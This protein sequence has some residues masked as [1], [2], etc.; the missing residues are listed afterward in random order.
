MKKLSIFTVV[1]V[2][3][4][5]TTVSSA[6]YRSY[7]DM[8]SNWNIVQK[9]SFATRMIAVYERSNDRFLNLI[10]R[11][12]RFSHYSWY[13]NLV[14]RYEWQLTEIARYQEV[15]NDSQA[16]LVVDTIV[17][18]VPGKVVQRRT[19]IEVTRDTKIVE[20]IFAGMVREY[21][22]TTVVLHTPVRTINYVNRKTTK[23]YSDGTR[24]TDSDVTVTSV[25]DTVDVETKV[26]REFLR[27][28]PVVVADRDNA[29][30]VPRME[31]L[32]EAEYLAL[33]DVNYYQSEVYYTAVKNMN[34][35]I[36]D[37]YTNEVLGKWFGNNLDT[38]GAPA[39]WSR[40][41]TGAGSKIAI[42]DT[43]IDLDHPEF[44]G[45]IAAAEC[46]S[47]ACE[48]GNE[49]IDDQNRYSHGT[50]VAGI[51]A[52]AFDGTG[53]TGVAPEAELLI[54]KLAHDW[55]FFDFSRL[56]DGIQWAVNQGADVMNVSANTNPDLI[57]RRSLI[58]L[59]DGTFY[60]ND[61][62]HGGLY[63][64]DGYNATYRSNTY[65]Q[66]FVEAMKGHEAILVMS[67]GN[68][69][70]PISGVPT[71]IALDDEV[72]DR[73]LVVGNYDMRTRDLYRGSNAAGTLCLQPT[74]DNQC[75]QQGRISDRYLMAPGLYIASTDR[76]GSYRT[77]SGTS[78]AAPHVAGAVAIVRQ[79]WPH[80]T[81]ANLSKLLLDTANTSDIVN[82]DRERH[83]RGLLDLDEA[84][85]SQGA[86]GI[87]TTGRVEGARVSLENGV[88][89][90]DNAGQLSAFE[91]VM[92]VDEYDRDF[93]LDANDLI[94]SLDTRTVS[95]IVHALGGVQPDMYIDYT[96]GL[97]LSLDQLAV[98][99]NDQ[100]G[101]GTVS[102]TVGGLTFGLQNEIGSF[103]GNIAQS[104]L[105][106]VNGAQTAYIGYQTDRGDYFA[107]LQVGATALDVDSSSL[108]KNADVLLSYSGTV[109]ARQSVGPYQLGATASIP[110]TIFDGDARFQMPS[111]VS[112]DGNLE[113]Q[114]VDSSLASQ[115]TPL[116]VGL[117]VS[118][119]LSDVAKLE[120]YAELRTSQIGT[121]Y[122]S[123]ELGFRYSLRF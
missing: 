18:D 50:H 107:N 39:A 28:Y 53:I 92:V 57:Y 116:D 4:I 2:L 87:P 37:W 66:D 70:M 10:E 48:Y 44:E 101:E 62:R 19:T 22:V 93:Y 26:E 61:Q 49:T 36:N 104:E 63:A 121:E 111:S 86:L 31:I 97:R 119:E 21:A 3:F 43:G 68:N 13:Q 96:H 117:F 123:G 52:A 122:E 5:S 42:F 12:S 24:H 99:M 109:G 106:R 65:Y 95:P 20:E 8:M 82:Y 69:A 77:L 80:M 103:L 47:A 34:S 55:G 84:T 115:S 11:F 56:D 71:N 102:L 78:M 46:L 110:V 51:A 94:V 79:M 98:I 45:R 17:E 113:Y 67:A 35:R 118:T 38:V 85:T 14:G 120:A 41:Y 54:G 64:R 32:T 15:L 100:T 76:D 9:Q 91:E 88:I 74:D 40:G 83:G 60:A 16:P 81:G 72:G 23:I 33:D 108:M 30:S 59:D 7:F 89:A 90:L 114:E 58:E 105:M 25:D 75:H 27:E 6:Q 1:A 112:Y 29:N 73:V